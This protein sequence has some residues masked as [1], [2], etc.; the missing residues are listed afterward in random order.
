MPKFRSKADVR[1][2]QMRSPFHVVRAGVRG[3]KYK[4]AESEDTT[5]A[6]DE[7]TAAAE[8]A[9]YEEAMAASSGL[10]PDFEV[11]KYSDME[12]GRMTRARMRRQMS[13]NPIMFG[14]RSMFT[15]P[16]TPGEM[17]DFSMEK[18]YA[19]QMQYGYA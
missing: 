6:I 8:A 1:G 2:F 17:Y 12:K 11:T 3:R 9:A 18:K 15:G 16:T 14:R 19:E 13:L 4:T 5:D 7:A 10:N